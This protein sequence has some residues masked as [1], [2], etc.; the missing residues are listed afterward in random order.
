M[1][2]IYDGITG[3]R[4]DLNLVKMNDGKSGDIEPLNLTKRNENVSDEHYIERGGAEPPSLA[5]KRL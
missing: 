5:V 1:R 2:R 4:G 3:R